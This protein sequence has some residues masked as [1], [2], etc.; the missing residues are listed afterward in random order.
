MAS[1][2]LD[3][4]FSPPSSFKDG[5]AGDRWRMKGENSGSER[6]R[7]TNDTESSV[8]G[9][10]SVGGGGGGGGNIGSERWSRRE[11]GADRTMSIQRHGNSR[12]RSPRRLRDRDGRR[13]G[14]GGVRNDRMVYIANIPYDVRWM[15][16]KDLVREKAGEVNF[17][18]LLEDRKGKSKGAAVVEFREKESVQRCVDALHRYP[19]NDRLLTAK[20][21]RDPVA[22]FR[23]VK[24]DTGV[25]FLNGLHGGTATAS[26]DT[27]NRQEEQFETYGL[28]PA[29]LRQLHITGPLTNRVFVSNLPYNVQSGRVTD[30]FSLAGKVTWVDLQLDK[31]GRSKGMAVVQ[32]THPI[33]AV[34]AISM[35]NNQRVFDRQINVKMD[36]FDPIDDRKEGELPVG[37]RGVGMG[38]GANGAPLGDVSS[39]IS[40]LTSSTTSHNSYDSTS[41]PYTT[42]S[43]YQGGPVSNL[44]PS[45][46]SSV[47]PFSSTYTSSSSASLSAPTSGYST[48]GGVGGFS[49][50]SIIIK[51]LPLDYTWQ[52]VRDRVQQFGPVDLTEM[53]APGCAKVTFTVASDAERA[54]KSLQNTTVEGRVIGVEFLA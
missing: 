9:S 42:Q 8:T 30:Y 15:E 48:F 45:S 13:S 23:K 5:G 6:W 28:S 49:S 25:D 24:E 31:E 18:E 40:S 1:S 21:I 44:Q 36:K 53:I 50:R 33:E 4:D 43:A 41:A 16:L 7:L 17:V 29:F 10:G 11:I 2:L 38:L 39:I 52:I 12:E 47:M 14:A 35:L 54:R 22:F 27:R 34:Q 46:I 19:M 37:L 3:R 26:L 20:E 51:N 32:F